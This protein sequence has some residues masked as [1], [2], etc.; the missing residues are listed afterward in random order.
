MSWPAR[1]SNNLFTIEAKSL[2][3]TF[4]NCE[5]VSQRN[6][7]KENLKQE[8]SGKKHDGTLCTQ[9]IFNAMVYEMIFMI[10]KYPYD[11]EIKFT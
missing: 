4:K 6:H 7:R 1:E 9:D 10:S 2:D 11:K 5:E 3:R 8:Y